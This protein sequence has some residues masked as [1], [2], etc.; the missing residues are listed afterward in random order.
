MEETGMTSVNFAIYKLL[1][2]ISKLIANIFL[3]W[4]LIII[5]CVISILCYKADLTLGWGL[6]QISHLK[7]KW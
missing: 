4:L 6:I 1:T 7:S 5:F 3:D 2:K